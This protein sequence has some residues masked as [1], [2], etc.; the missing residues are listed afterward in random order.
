MES[1]VLHTYTVYGIHYP[2][3]YESYFSLRDKSE[4]KLNENIFYTF[5]YLHK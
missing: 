1:I 3:P 5:Y 4:I 2:L